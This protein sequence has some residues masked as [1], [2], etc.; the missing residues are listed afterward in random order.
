MKCQI[1]LWCFEIYIYSIH[2]GFQI[3]IIYIFMF[4]AEA[5]YDNIQNK[6]EKFKHQ[7]WCDTRFGSY[8]YMKI[9]MIQCN[10]L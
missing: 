2:I 6:Q 8:T 9:Q 1:F 3:L 4:K 10:H 5:V 7:L